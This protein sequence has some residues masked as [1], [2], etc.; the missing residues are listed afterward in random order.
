[1]YWLKC[2]VVCFDVCELG[3]LIV[4][5]CVFILCYWCVCV[6]CGM[7]G[8]VFN[9]VLMFCGVMCDDCESVDECCGDWCVVCDVSVMLWD[10]GG[11]GWCGKVVGISGCEGK[12]KVWSGCCVVVEWRWGFV[13][14]VV[15]DEFGV[16]VVYMGWFG[17]IVWWCVGRER[18]GGGVA[19][20]EN[21]RR[22]LRGGDIGG[23]FGL[24]GSVSDGYWC[25]CG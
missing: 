25:G 7:N 1:M 17:W 18:V 10:V 8:V 22:R 14:G 15:C 24:I 4:F 20:V 13:C 19:R 12:G 9:D 2:G 5:G 11:E 23:E 6:M 16:G 21:F 3:W